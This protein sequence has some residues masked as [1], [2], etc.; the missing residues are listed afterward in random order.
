MKRFALIAWLLVFAAIS[1]QAQPS[2]FPKLTGP[3]LGQKPPGKTAEP[4]GL[5][6]TGL[7]QNLHSAI[8]F[9]PDGR[10]AYWKPGWNP[11]DPIF[12]S[13]IENGL[14]SAPH[15]APFSAPDQGD[16]SPFISPDGKKL[17][18][19][20]QRQERG[21]VVI[22]VMDRLGEGWSEP[23]P[24]PIAVESVRTHWQLS[25]D[26]EY[27]VYFGARSGVDSGDIYYAKYE[28]GQ[29]GKPE[30]LGPA[31]N[32]DGEYNYSP[33]V[34]ADGSYLVFTR[35]QKPAK[36]Y[37]SFRKTDGTWTAAR[38]IGGIIKSERGQNSFVTADEKYLFFTIGGRI[39]W[40]DAGFIEEMR[41]SAG[42]SISASGEAPEKPE[43]KLDDRLLI[44]KPFIG[45]TWVGSIPDDSRMG[46]ITLHWEVLLNG[47]A[48]RL[49]RNILKFDHWLETTYYWDESSKK[50]AYLAL[51]NNGVV[52]KG[53][54]VGRG[55]E[56]ISE[57]DQ[58]GPDVNRKVRRIYRLDKKGKLYEDD[59]F[60][61]S[62]A[63]EWQRTHVSVFVAK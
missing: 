31:V 20:S 58:R 44:W 1:I 30:K 26:R 56:L 52:S 24:L 39:H 18:F 42:A 60:R 46:E 22:W 37:I 17:F 43:T 14:W 54:I 45:P 9:S 25:V 40:A 41:L 6:I 15:V 12:T 19:I 51:S 53:F 11:R 23:K 7:Q 21:K 34:A 59:Q 57:G 32:K 62:D 27:T 13:R 49:R 61:N 8:I 16:D 50:I 36:L 33:C 5:G 63:G 2:E 48:V 10:E 3:Y 35:S 4:F 29:Y 38:D 55:D 47:F 28:N